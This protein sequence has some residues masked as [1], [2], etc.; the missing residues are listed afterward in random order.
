MWFLIIAYYQTDP[1]HPG[2][3][4]GSSLG[5]ASGNH[6]PG[7]G[8]TAVRQPEPVACLTISVAGYRTGIQDVDISTGFRRNQAMPCL[9]KLPGELFRLGLI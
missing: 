7:P 6:Q 1:F 8:V 3:F 5:I 9:E 4:I 2:Q